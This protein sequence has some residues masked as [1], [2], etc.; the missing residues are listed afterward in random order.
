MTCDLSGQDWRKKR[1]EVW[2][3]RKGQKTKHVEDHTDIAHATGQGNANTPQRLSPHYALWATGHTQGCWEHA[4]WLLQIKTSGKH[5]ISTR[6]QSLMEKT[7]NVKYQINN[8][9]VDY[10]LKW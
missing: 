3:N 7:N 6:F 2:E 4:M 9:K 5:K 1:E 10:K 8:L